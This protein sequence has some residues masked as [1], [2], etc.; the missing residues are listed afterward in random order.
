MPGMPDIVAA[1]N[2]CADTS[3]LLPVDP[4]TAVRYHFGMLLGV[5]DFETDQAYHRGKNRLG[6]AWSHRAGVL[7]GLGV[8]ADLPSGEIRV[9]PGLALDAAGEELHLDAEA[10]LS[11]GAWF[12]AHQSDAGFVPNPSDGGFTF[13]AH[14]EIK[15]H[16][17]LTRQVPAMSEPCTG[18]AGDTAYSRVFETVELHLVPGA[19]SPLPVPY[20]R[21]RLLFALEDPIQNAGVVVPSDQEVLD[22]RTHVLSLAAAAQPA[23][24]LDAFRRFAALDEIDLAPAQDPEGQGSLLFPV[25]DA[26]PVVLANLTG[27]SIAG[28]AGNWTLKTATVDPTIRPSHVATAT[29]QELLCGPLLSSFG[30]AGDA[31]GPRIDPASVKTTGTSVTMTVAGPLEAASVAPAAF[32]VSAFGATGW[33]TLDVNTAVYSNVDNTITLTL[34]ATGAGQLVRVIARGTG[35][36]P[37]LG[38]NKVPLGG[39]VGGP[40]GTADDGNDFVLMQEGS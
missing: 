28:Q 32:T 31:G 40:A 9:E 22:A 2:G 17:C 30:S 10:C 23:A 27:I 12:D 20:H 18:A 26:T 1:A 3:A 38:T 7:W 5:D 13:A 4:F 14:V 34:A 11:V 33:T 15:F 29:I 21:L 16:P 36:H 37:L 6:N 25:P 39:A 35:D 24:Y 8:K 19:A